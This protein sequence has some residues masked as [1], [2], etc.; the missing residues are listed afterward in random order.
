MW[1]RGQPCVAEAESEL[2][3]WLDFCGVEV[4]VIDEEAFCEV[5][6]PGV[7]TRSLG[8]DVDNRSVVV[9]LVVGD[10]VREL[11]CWADNAIQDIHDGVSYLLAWKV[12]GDDGSDVWVVGPWH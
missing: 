4:S 2:V 8:G 1:R 12:C 5:C 10:C 9:R 6:L 11:S 3:P 7:C